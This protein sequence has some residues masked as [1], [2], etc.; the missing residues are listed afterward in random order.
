MFAWVSFG[1]EHDPY[2]YASVD[3]DKFGGV[4]VPRSP[5]FNE[6][7][8]SDK[9]S[10]VGNL[11]RLSDAEVTQMDQDYADGLR[12][13]MRVDRF[14][15][16]ASDLLRSKGEMGNTYFVFYSDNGNHFG[17]H[18]LSHGKLQPYK[19]DTNFPLILRGPGIPH[20]AKSGK[21][22]GNHD[23]APTL[24]RMG[25]ASVPAFVDGRS[26]LTLAKDPSTT[27][28]RT[29]ILSEKEINL[30]PPNVWDMLRMEDRN[31]TRYADG[32]PANDPDPIEYYDLG[33]DPYQV[34]NAFST[35]DT[36]PPA[37][38]RPDSATQGY[39]EDRLDALYGCTGQSCRTAENAPRLPTG[40]V[41]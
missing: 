23:I 24:T 16:R 36:D 14:I 29:A 20:G 13:L 4:G 32:D 11:P 22:V 15:A 30:E 39:Y 26:F 9:P 31:Y 41:P 7:D 35:S 18:R 12:S 1:A 40:I 34:H 33:L 10:Y 5:S 25:G 17:Q 6:A 27:W 37:Y 2:H 8:V 19:E 38:P 21:L 3:A 28:P